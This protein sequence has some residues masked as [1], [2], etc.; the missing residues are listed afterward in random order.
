MKFS[1]AVGHGPRTSQLDFGG[2]P[3][4][5]PDPGFLDLNQDPS[6]GVFSKLFDEIFWGVGHDP[7]NSRLDIDGDPDY[8][9]EPS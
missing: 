4:R 3:A 7:K 8:S 6:P 1:V 2:N 5:N 9:L